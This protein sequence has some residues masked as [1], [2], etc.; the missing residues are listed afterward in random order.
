MVSL[1][2]LFCIRQDLDLDVERIEE[3]FINI[4]VLEENNSIMS[5]YNAEHQNGKSLGTYDHQKY[6][7]TI[8]TPYLPKEDE[9]IF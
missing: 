9:L 5:A 2:P 6:L 7:A 4:G 8:P 1:S 3:V